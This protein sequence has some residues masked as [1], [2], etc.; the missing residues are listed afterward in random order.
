[1]VF[2]VSFTFVKFFSSKKG[3]KI[4]LDAVGFMV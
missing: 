1:L 3:R 4:Q 2:S